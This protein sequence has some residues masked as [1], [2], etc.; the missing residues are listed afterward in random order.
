MQVFLCQSRENTQIKEVFIFFA[1]S[2]DR[3]KPKLYKSKC[4]DSQFGKLLYLKMPLEKIFQFQKICLPKR[5]KPLQLATD[6]KKTETET[7]NV[8]I[9]GKKFFA[10]GEGISKRPAVV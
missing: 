10:I 8:D 9:L 1:V 5:T 6:P 4:F 2:P 3:L 7:K